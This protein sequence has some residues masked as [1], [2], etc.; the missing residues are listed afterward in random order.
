[1][2]KKVKMTEIQ[3]PGLVIREKIGIDAV[4]EL[5]ESIA[6][7][8]L[9]QPILLRKNEEGYEIIA[10]HRRYLASKQLGREV[11]EAKIVTLDEDNTILARV[12]ENLFR[13]D[14][15]AVDEANIVGFLHYEQKWD[16]PVIQQKLRKSKAWVCQRIDVF[17]MPDNLKDALREKKISIALANEI[18]KES[19]PEKQ[20]YFLDMAITSGAT[21]RQVMQWVIDFKKE[22][23]RPDLLP[24]SELI[25]GNQPLPVGIDVECG[26][27]G[28]HMAAGQSIA[29]NTCHG[30]WTEIYKQKKQRETIPT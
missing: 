8:G 17:H 30:C 7:V 29:I 5:A 9:L 19:E 21:A 1:M 16:L 27:C 15:T 23:F 22:S 2:I 14:I 6:E 11:I 25:K 20:K 18:I 10:G 24:P 26:I 13:E 4:T 28:T 12:H 3:E